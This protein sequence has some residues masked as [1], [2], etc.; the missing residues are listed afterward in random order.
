MMHFRISTTLESFCNGK[1]RDHD[2]TRYKRAI[3]KHKLEALIRRLKNTNIN[4]EM[5]DGWI[6]KLQAFFR[7]FLTEI[8][9]ELT[10]SDQQNTHN[11]PHSHLT[12]TNYL[13][14]RIQNV[15]NEI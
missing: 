9:K 13:L 10:T 5:G 6:V 3:Q 11:R 2:I 4:S 1:E 15:P 14:V 8:M 7:A 12:A